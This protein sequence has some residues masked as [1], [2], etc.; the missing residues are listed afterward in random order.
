MSASEGLRLAVGTFT[1][2]PSGRVTITPDTARAA[3]L[4]APL[5]FLMRRDREEEP[6]RAS[7]ASS[8]AA[9]KDEGS[10]V[11]DAAVVAVGG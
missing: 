2:Y 1:R 9:T 6:G 8:G 10:Y 4:L 11:G 7:A 3:L 5:E